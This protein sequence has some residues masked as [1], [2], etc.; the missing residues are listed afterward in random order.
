MLKPGMRVIEAYVHSGYH[1]VQ[2]AGEWPQPMLAGI[3]GAMVL[4]D[5][6][7]LGLPWVPAP[8][9][10]SHGASTSDPILCSQNAGPSQSN[11]SLTVSS[12]PPTGV[13]PHFGDPALTTPPCAMVTEDQP[14]GLP[15]VMSVPTSIFVSSLGHVSPGVVEPQFSSGVVRFRLVGWQSVGC[16]GACAPIRLLRGRVGR[17]FR[18]AIHQ[19]LQ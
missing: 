15:P 16:P 18:R 11:P 13:P 1:S 14:V 12:D 4:S 10:R 7:R 5:S 6:E 3:K 9:H 8:S 17:P 2:A 19:R